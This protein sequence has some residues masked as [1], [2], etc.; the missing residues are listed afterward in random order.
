MF[1]MWAACAGASPVQI[2]EAPDRATLWARAGE[3]AA[4]ELIYLDARLPAVEDD[5]PL[6]CLQTGHGGHTVAETITLYHRQDHHLVI[7]IWPSPRHRFPFHDAS[8]DYST[9][10]PSWYAA[11]IR[12]F[13]SVHTSAIP[14]ANLIRLHPIALDPVLSSEIVTSLDALPLSRAR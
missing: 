10:S 5:D 14:T 13:Y 9:Q 2:L 3:L 6:G 1:W 11:R 7:E 8:C 12:G 4:G